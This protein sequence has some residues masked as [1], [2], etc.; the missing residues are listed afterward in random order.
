VA[1][2]SNVIAREVTVNKEIH[3]GTAVLAS[4]NL[5]FRENTKDICV[6]FH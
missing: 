6:S 5:I 1:W 3:E 2:L 4:H